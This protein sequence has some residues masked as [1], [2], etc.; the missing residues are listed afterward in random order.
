MK[1]E[2]YIITDRVCVECGG[3]SL[4]ADTRN[5]GVLICLTCTASYS[6]SY[7]VPEWFFHNVICDE[8]WDEVRLIVISDADNDAVASL[9]STDIPSPKYDIDGTPYS[10]IEKFEGG[11]YC[12]T[13]KVING[14]P[15]RVLA[16]LH[17]SVASNNPRLI[18][19]D[20]EGILNGNYDFIFLEDTEIGKA[21]KK[22]R[23]LIMSHSEVRNLPNR[24]PQADEELAH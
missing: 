12:I 7:A 9:M 21:E 18:L 24:V 3:L 11:A 19:E 8:D 5:P 17:D 23:L 13:V 10:F 1:K 2:K 20:D 4:Q 22:L 6:D 15:P 16:E 14:T